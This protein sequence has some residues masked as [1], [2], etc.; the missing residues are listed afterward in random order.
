[1]ATFKK[2]GYRLVLFILSK[3]NKSGNGAAQSYFLF[4]KLHLTS[5]FNPKLDFDWLKLSMATD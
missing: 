2:S 1:M 4:F 3:L 5:C